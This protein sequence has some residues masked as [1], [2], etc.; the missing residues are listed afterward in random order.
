M[1]IGFTLLTQP[2][3]TDN[4]EGILN[5]GPGPADLILFHKH[6]KVSL[7]LIAFG[8]NTLSIFSFHFKTKFDQHVHRLYGKIP[9]VQ[10][11]PVAS[12][13]HSV[14]G[15]VSAGSAVAPTSRWTRGATRWCTGWWKVGWQFRCTFCRIYG[16]KQRRWIIIPLATTAGLEWGCSS[17]QR[18][19]SIFQDLNYVFYSG[20]VLPL[21]S[22]LVLFLVF[23]TEEMLLKVL[24]NYD[25]ATLYWVFKF[26][27]ISKEENLKINKVK[28]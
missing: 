7:W 19:G 28:F 23:F 16:K 5:T 4:W 25:L 8:R 21:T 3:G 27:F 10:S 26:N 24:K 13:S 6:C 12:I 11:L 14:A 17:L 22:C 2:R 20:Y 1:E 9:W 18:K 15:R